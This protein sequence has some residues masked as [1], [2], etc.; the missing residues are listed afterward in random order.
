MHETSHLGALKRHA[1]CGNR[2]LIDTKSHFAYSQPYQKQ[3]I[4]LFISQ[5]A[6]SLDPEGF[7]NEMSEMPV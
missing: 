1:I 3:N 5:I 4:D 2:L 7:N 6:L